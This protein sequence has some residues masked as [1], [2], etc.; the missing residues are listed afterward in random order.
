MIT[1]WQ[2]VAGVTPQTT[3]CTLFTQ[4][5]SSILRRGPA[6]ALPASGCQRS[7]TSTCSTDC[8][9]A[10]RL[11]AAQRLSRHA[12]PLGLPSS[13]LPSLYHNTDVLLLLRILGRSCQAL[14]SRQTAAQQAGNPVTVNGRPA[15]DDLRVVSRTPGAGSASWSCWQRQ[16]S[17]G[18]RRRGGLPRGHRPARGAAVHPLVRVLANAGERERARSPRLPSHLRG[19]LPPVTGHGG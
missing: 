11:A 5:F 16:R 7:G 9:L 19:P 8:S 10:S 12:R 4:T 17:P 1:S 13:S 15:A 18:V 14:D 2:V 3:R 6:G